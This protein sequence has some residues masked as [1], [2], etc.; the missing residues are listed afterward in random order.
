M[1]KPKA[2]ER[3]R[4]TKKG[5]RPAPRKAGPA[6]AAQGVP[7]KA[8]K[9][10]DAPAAGPV[11]GLELGESFRQAVQAALTG[12]LEE[13]YRVVAETVEELGSRFDLA[14]ETL[15]GAPRFLDAV[16]RATDAAMRDS[17][18]EKREM[19]RNAVLNAAMPGAPDEDLQQVFFRFAD[20]LG[21]THVSMLR[22]IRDPQES[23]AEPDA[24]LYRMR[25]IDVL[26]KRLGSKAGDPATFHLFLEDLK[27][28]GLLES[29]V[30]AGS[31]DS[32]LLGN[33]SLTSM[34]RRFLDFL[35]RPPEAERGEGSR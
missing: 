32:V 6:D 11:A 28:R 22:L 2:P 25:L 9:A 34:G 13:W 5:L 30:R 26:V 17:R 16:Q 14:P 15:A 1:K 10:A 23:P 21:P 19:L 27:A 18:T 29:A 7:A 24:S 35:S 31:L 12:R 20:E 3:P 4:A 8:P 33:V